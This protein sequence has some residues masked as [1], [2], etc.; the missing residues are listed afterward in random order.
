MASTAQNTLEP[1][2]AAGDSKAKDEDME[3]ELEYSPFYGIEK[4]AV[5]QE[6]RCFNDSHVDPRRCQ[7]V[8]TK[9]LYLLTQGE[10]FTKSEASEVFFSVTKLFQHKDVHLRRMVYLVIKE[11]IP[12][13][14]E[15]III[16]SSLMKD[17]NSKNDLYRANAIRVLCRI[18]DSQML[19]QIERYLKQAVVDKS[20]V[21]ASAVLA[22]AIHLASASGE[23]IKR[24]SNEVQEAITS[25]HPMVQFQAVALMHALRAND[26]LAVSKLVTQLTRSNVRSPMAQCLLVRYVAQVIAESQPGVGNE[27]R[28]F[29]DF[30]ESC[31]RNKSEVVIFEA[32]RAICNMRDVT[33]RELTP[34]VTV[35]QLFLSSSKP[36]LRFA[37]VRTLNKVAMSHPM[38]VTS[39]NIDMESLIAD[40]NRS[41]AT[42]AITT[43]LK[44][45][46]ESSID[47]LLKQIGGFMSEIADEFKVV[48]VEAIKALC[49]KFP[50]KYRGLMNFLS[51][52]LREDGGFEY[53]KA[54]VDA[55]LVL[56]RDIP[57]AKEMGL[58]QLCEFIEDCE[59]TFLSVQILHLLGDE[60][61]RT[62]EPARY[63][64]YIYNRVILENATVRA[65]ALSSLARF[66]AHCPEL[67]ERI[68]ILIRRAQFDHDDEVRDRATLYLY[69]LE[70][71]PQ[72]PE[73]VDPHWRIPARG[74]EAA[75]QQ[76]LASPDTEQPFDLSTIPEAVAASPAKPKAKPQGLAAAVA[77]GTSAP[78]APETL[79][80][81]YADMLK[82]VP[83][84]AA[85]GPVFKTCPAL[86]LTEEETEY[87][88]V[89]VR[90]ILE[91]HLVFQFNCTNTVREQVLEHVS[92]AV[93]LDDLEAFSEELSLPLR[94]MPGQEEG[95]GQT[96]V[97]LARPPGSLAYGSFLATLRFRVKEIDPTT[98]EA[99]E[100]G[101]EDEY[102]LESV[103]VSPADYIKPAFTPNFRAAWEALP[104]DSEMMDDY[105]IGQRDSLQDA[106]E[107]VGRILGMQACEGTDA[108]PP[109]ARSHTLLLSG[110][111]VGD[112]QVLVRLSFGIDAQRNVAMKLA[113]RSESS[114]VSEAIHAI[115]QEA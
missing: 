4:G 71:A 72:G 73:S 68:L 108:V 43:L 31:L 66:G 64:R 76:Y 35:L 59:F 29:Y 103:E 92:V 97:V 13:S 46:N 65:A 58:A 99:E 42:L 45:G 23:V 16:T 52:V 112:V 2:R 110:T 105:G 50:Q 79:S 74:L 36:V 75:L 98:G 51:N 109:N 21:V 82:A 57:E 32:A 18:I 96:Y 41:I 67:R 3:E 10:S 87:K 49:L 12:S 94:V 77:A 80:G 84:L 53:K 38:A 28:P 20:A 33:T 26:R 22:G 101:Y 55:I 61:P 24:W 115:I 5:L 104:E 90:H 113:V 93:D 54:I 106:V 89:C 7:Q 60:G 86:Q 8:I 69:Q 1:L 111:V 11:I 15:V 30:L 27:T 14:D 83:Q 17:M 70:K 85:L 9:L 40:P 47:R 34:A 48:V 95:A 102:Q 44:T 100:E 37:A 63:I 88:V 81:E 114:D 78:G 19:L 62:K 39:C 56:I 25:R 91:G 107:A 6:A